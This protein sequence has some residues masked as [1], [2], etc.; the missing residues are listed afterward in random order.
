MHSSEPTP[1]GKRRDSINAKLRY[2]VLQR[3]N[4][5]CQRCGRSV[6]DGIKLN[7]DH[8]IPV[9]MGGATT[10]DNLWALCD[11]CN[12]GKK[13]LFSDED[14]DLLQEIMSMSSAYKKLKTYFSAYPNMTINPLK[15]ETVSGVRDWERV[16]RKIR[17]DEQMSITFVRPTAQDPLGG[18]IYIKD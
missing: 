3:D 15:L 2:A 18:Y 12:G 7:I 13:N 5:V 11:E 17:A 16:I 1:T 8:R 6:S 14:A 9:D 10:L 4:S